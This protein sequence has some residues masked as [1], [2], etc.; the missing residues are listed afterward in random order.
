MRLFYG[1][2]GLWLIVGLLCLAAGAVIPPSSFTIVLLPDTQNYTESDP[3]T[4][5]KQARE[6]VRWRDSA[7]IK[8]V[9]HLGDLTDSNN[10]I[11]WQWVVANAAHG[12]LEDSKVPYSV[13]PGNHDMPYTA[14]PHVRDDSMLSRDLDMFNAVFGPARFSTQR[15]PWSGYGGHMP[16]AP[17]NKYWFFEHA[18]RRFM[19]LGLEMAPRKDAMCWANQLVKQHEDR[20]VIVTTHC[21]QTGGGNHK[22]D[23]ATNYGLNGAGGDV[24]FDELVRRHTNIIMV[25]S[26]HVNAAAHKETA[27]IFGTPVH[28]IIT[29]YQHEHVPLVAP[30]TG[31]GWLRTMTFHPD[32]DSVNVLA[33]TV[34]PDI[35]RF[36]PTYPDIDADYDES[37]NHRDHTFAF[38]LDLGTLRN[39]RHSE[40]L[41]EFH[42]RTVN[43]V[44]T[45]QQLD[46]AVGANMQGDVMVAWEDDT[47]DNGSM[48]IHARML[49][50]NGCA[51]FALRPVNTHSDGNQRNP[52]VAM[53][54]LGN[55]VIVW[56]DNRTGKYD[57]RVRGFRRDGTQRFPEMTVNANTSGQ[58][59]NPAV[60]MDDDGNFVVTWEDD[61]NENGVYE[62]R[63]RRFPA[64]GQAGFAEF[65]PNLVSAGQQRMPHVAMSANG[66]F[67]IVWADNRD[68]DAFYS[69]RASSFKANGETKLPDFVVAS[70]RFPATVYLGN[71]AAPRVAIDGAGRFAVTWADDK[72]GNGKFQIRVRGFQPNR[73][74]WF[75]E[76]TA[77]QIAAGQQLRSDVAMNRDGGFVVVWSDS[78][79]EETD[80]VKAALAA[81]EVRARE[82][83]A[84]GSPGPEEKTINFNRAGEQG[85]PAVATMSNTGRYVV[86]WQDDL[87]LNDKYEI[88]A[89]G[90]PA[91]PR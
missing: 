6:I 82:F 9:V 58:Q 23:C 42:D 66:S 86:V 48:Q 21:Y 63:A 26:G 27:T 90:M 44:S 53:D 29:D 56:E 87:N 2:R 71:T 13:V 70:E 36:F 61:R 45:G 72:D 74:S 55:T 68:S 15:R 78:R 28:E 24:L 31:N 34:R 73:D 22:K 5:Y 52:D 50:A 64:N 7:N 47:D 88:L 85:K 4:Y 49:D 57:I 30:K 35:T 11:P 54:K 81:T 32:K 12:I 67:V 84:A 39:V 65:K 76:R 51:R 59:L 8:F 41:A 33:R 37:P 77:N 25:L 69:V 3:E 10:R 83:D 38:Y 46:P 19:V 16:G 91:P 40:N 75:A 62:I 89:R 14:S 17:E 18:S 79:S 43:S 1:R 80:W 20:R 60:A